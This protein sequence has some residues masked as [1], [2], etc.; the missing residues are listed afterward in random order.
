MRTFKPARAHHLA[1]ALT[2]LIT[3]WTPGLAGA[4]VVLAQSD[5]NS[6]SLQDGWQIGEVLTGNTLGTPGIFIA[7]LTAHDYRLQFT[8]PNPYGESASGWAAPA[9]FLGDQRAA[10]GGVLR[11]E[12]SA[13][14]GDS[15][16]DSIRLSDGALELFY[17]APPPDSINIFEMTS[18]VVPLDPGAGWWTAGATRFDPR[19]PTT[20]AEMLLVL[21]DLSSLTIRADYFEPGTESLATLDNVQLISAVPEPGSWALMSAGLLALGRAAMKRRQA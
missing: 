15:G 18:Y 21:S 16:R 1:A 13:P 19:T 17:R 20:R 8:L 3:L 6:P 5:F 9:K 2:A 4:Q 12:L 11:F 14:Q 10:L 7:D